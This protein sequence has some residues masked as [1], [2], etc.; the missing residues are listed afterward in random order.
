MDGKLVLNKDLIRIF[1]EPISKE[2]AMKSLASLLEERG[3]VKNTFT[4]AVLDR[5]IVFPTGLPTQP[6]GIAIPHT[7]SEHVNRGAIAVGILR[8]PVSFQE[9]GD[10]DSSV[11]VSI[12]SMLAIDDPKLVIP[13]LRKLAGAF[14]DAEFLNG[15]KFAERPEDVISQYK[16][17]LPDTILL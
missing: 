6:Y 9:M 13:T 15:L 11:D 12:I 16:R 10:L 17:I 14:Q 4:K 2:D 5:E 3:F 8:F 7:D 1:T